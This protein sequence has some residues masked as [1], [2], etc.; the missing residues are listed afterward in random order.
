MAVGVHAAVSAWLGWCV[1]RKRL[2]PTNPAAQVEREALNG[3]IVVWEWPELVA[4]VRAAEAL[5]FASIADA[6]VL[7]VDLSFGEQDLLALTWGDVTADLRVRHRRIKTGVAGAPPLLAIG[8]DRL[9]QIAAR[10]PGVTP[11]PGAPILVCELT[12]RAWSA[13]TFR[14]R[15]AQVR[16][17]AARD[18]PGAAAKQFRDLRDTAI[19][20]AQEAGL[21]LTE[22]C[23]RSLHA[24]ARAQ[25]VIDKH[26][27][28]I[29]QGVANAGAA[30]LEAH[31]AGMGYSFEAPRDAERLAA[32]EILAQA[33]KVRAWA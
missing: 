29:R 15:F 18:H 3:R 6:V 17:L 12:G 20:Y 1:K 31:F 5:G 25:A 23:S 32:P 10:R 21:G 2:W 14:H 30:K 24:P 4:L 16:A 13:D 9:R 33:E 19:T 22:I 28:A 26:Y 11:L 8:R 7:A 27:G